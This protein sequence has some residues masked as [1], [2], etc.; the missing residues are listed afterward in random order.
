[1]IHSIPKSELKTRQQ[2][3]LGLLSKNQALL[4]LSNQV[5]LRNSDTDYR[6][7][8]D[9]NFWYFTGF[10]EDKA[11]VLFLD[12]K[13]Y[14][15]AKE[16]DN[17]SETWTGKITGLERAKSLVNADQ[18]YPFEKLLE[19]VKNKAAKFKKIFFDLDGNSFVKLRS[20]LEELFLDQ[21]IK[22]KPESDLTAQL[23]MYK[24]N[25][26][27]EQMQNAAQI[28]MLAHQRIGQYLDNYSSP[29]KQNFL[30]QSDKNSLSEYQLQAILDYTFK[31]NACLEA[32]PPIV[33]SGNNATTLHYWQNNKSFKASDLI[34]IDAA[35]ELNY[36]SSDITR[37]YCANK[38][39]S[40]QQ[41]IYDLVLKANKQVIELTKNHAQKNITLQQLQLLSNQILSQGLLDLGILKGK[42]EHILENN[43]YR[44]YYMHGI[45][46]WLGLD[47]HD[48]GIYKDD[49]NNP[50][51]LKAGMSFTVEPGLYFK[52]EDQN[53]PKKYRGLGIRI[54]D[55]IVLT[56]S[57]IIN[58]TENLS[59]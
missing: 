26:E 49:S 32:Y 19:V 11:A 35:C 23:R 8:Q 15:F 56:E 59:K 57:G 39:S 28:S 13:I 9:S 34:L 47:T 20:Q 1:M 2:K 16:K 29:N 54:E 12:G 10:D 48:Q 43:S 18:V 6:F 36:Y 44:N 25:W 53:V 31:Q 41:E 38:F 4:I 58:L 27:I 5:F 42:I 14:L 30:F 7:R 50:T 46:H 33:A 52:A 17:F 37:V 3:I 51:I 45:S 55:N 22:V 21:Q 24:S 40:A